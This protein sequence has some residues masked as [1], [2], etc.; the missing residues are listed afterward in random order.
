V[1]KSHITKQEFRE[2]RVPQSLLRAHSITQIPPCPK[3]QN[4]HHP[5]NTTTLCV[6]PVITVDAWGPLKPH[7]N[8]SIRISM[9]GLSSGLMRDNRTVSKVSINFQTLYEHI[10]LILL[11]TCVGMEKLGCAIGVYSPFY[12]TAQPFS[13]LVPFC[14]PTSSK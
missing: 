5:P 9:V 2:R 4:F 6:K 10:L 1:W 13:E 11:N 7:L 3:S 14:N 12:K 8:H